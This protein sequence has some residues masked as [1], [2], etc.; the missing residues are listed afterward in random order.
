MYGL[1]RKLGCDPVRSGGGGLVHVFKDI[2]IQGCMD[3][4]GVIISLR[5]LNLLNDCVSCR[6][7]PISRR[8]DGG[9]GMRK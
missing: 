8:N 5:R 3:P 6:L 1:R 2:G 7:S 9:Q 4:S